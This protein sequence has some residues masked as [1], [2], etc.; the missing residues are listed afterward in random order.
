MSNFNTLAQDFLAQKRIAVAGVSRGG[1]DA[2]NGIYKILRDKGYQV[3]AVNPNADTVEGDPCFPNLQAIPGGVDGVLIST[4][5]ELVEG[6]VHDAKQAGVP[7]VWMHDNTF[8]PGSS[9][10]AAAAYCRENGITVI[11]A[12]CP[13]MFFD[14]GHK[15]MKWMMGVMGRLPN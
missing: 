1:Q 2:A 11:S 15:C 12:G 9:S 13:L 4:K 3:F 8:M 5:P 10:E 6:I 7:R 14:F